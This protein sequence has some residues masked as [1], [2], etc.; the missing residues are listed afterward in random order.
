[1]IKCPPRL[2]GH[3]NARTV[4]Q[5]GE[6][7]KEAPKYVLHLPLSLSIYLFGLAP[8]S[9]L[10]NTC[11]SDKNSSVLGLPSLVDWVKANFSKPRECVE[12]TQIPLARN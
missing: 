12:E 5:K 4:Y 10:L 1:L 3:Q 9:S 6:N 11:S 2:V 8:T 7:E